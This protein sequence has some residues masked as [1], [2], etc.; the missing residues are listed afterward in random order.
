MDTYVVGYN[1]PIKFVA[2]HQ[3]I[4]IYIYIKPYVREYEVSPCDTFVKRIEILSSTTSEIRTNEILTFVLFDLI[5]RDFFN[6]KTEII[7][8]FWFN[9][10]RFFLLRTYTRSSLHFNSPFSSLALLL[11]SF[12]YTYP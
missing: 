10:S 5:F 6:K 11:Y 1:A 7:C 3:Y 4:Y 8:L 9:I 2:K 12:I